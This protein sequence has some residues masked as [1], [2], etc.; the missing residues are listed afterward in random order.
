MPSTADPSLLTTAAPMLYWA[1]RASSSRTVA[2]GRIVTMSWMA[3]PA[4][5]SLIFMTR[6]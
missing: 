1:S 5:T 6:I 2:S 3:L 4:M